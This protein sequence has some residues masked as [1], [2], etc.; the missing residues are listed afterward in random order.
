M[1][2]NGV[3]LIKGEQY[4]LYLAPDLCYLYKEKYRE[5]F[6]SCVFEEA[7]ITTKPVQSDNVSE[8]EKDWNLKCDIYF[9]KTCVTFLTFLDETGHDFTIPASYVF[10]IKRA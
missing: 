4:K 3:D 1:K 5:D 6:I 10:S 7:D 9:G 2:M 8:E